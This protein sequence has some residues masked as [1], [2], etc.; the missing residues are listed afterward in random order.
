MSELPYQEFASDMLGNFSSP[1]I[2]DCETQSSR[3]TLELRGDPR[4]VPSLGRGATRALTL[5][6]HGFWT[7]ALSA[8]LQPGGQVS[9]RLLVASVKQSGRWGGLSVV[10]RN[11]L[12][13]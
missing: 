5:C 13:T 4:R 11:I 2:A 7:T 10:R 1:K 3:L 6:H 9:L 8:K 12:N